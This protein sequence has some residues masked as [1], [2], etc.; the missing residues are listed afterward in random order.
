MS[1]DIVGADPDLV[2]YVDR[3]SEPADAVQ[4]ALIE[5]TTALGG[6]SMVQ[7][8]RAQGAFME[9]LVRAVAPRL[10]VEV[11][12]FTG[13]SALSI[14]KAL[15]DHGRLICCDVST[16]W[17]A[18]ASEHWARAGVADKIDLRIGPAIET[19]RQLP[20]EPAVD[21][22]FI[23]ADKPGYI[24][25][26]EELL[27]R[28]SPHGVIAVDNTLWSGAVVDPTD[29]SADTVAIRAFNDHV[30]ADPRTV[31]ALT[32]IGDGVTLISHR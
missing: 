3:H 2:D 27:G 31:V 1:R 6:V 14:A 20:R 28:L 4:E 19:L 32:T 13:Y 12:T 16:D 9:V 25:Y 24:D 23:D 29:E 18:I 30:A 21:F 10:A 7:I 5:A 15:P 17:T 22:A 11:G 26:Y 8:G